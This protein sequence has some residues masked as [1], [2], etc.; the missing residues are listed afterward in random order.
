VQQITALAQ[1]ISE[2]NKT[3]II[4]GGLKIKTSRATSA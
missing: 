2:I 4:F 3:K 1:L